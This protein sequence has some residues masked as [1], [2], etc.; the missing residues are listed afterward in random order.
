MP[1]RITGSTYRKGV[2]ATAPTQEAVMDPSVAVVLDE[3]FV[4]YDSTDTYTATQATAGTAAISTTVPGALLLDA[5]ATTDNQGINLQR[6][7]TVFLPAA[8]KSIW[9]EFSVILT[10]ATPPVTVWRSWASS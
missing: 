1:P 3:Q 10:A 5:G 4:N 9:A 6:L 7:K 2:W 8:N